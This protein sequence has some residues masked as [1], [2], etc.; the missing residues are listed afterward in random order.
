MQ[1]S[2]K[3]LTEMSHL[4]DLLI[5]NAEELLS[6]VHK[7]D[8]D[9]DKLRELQKIQDD[10]LTEYIL[11]DDMWREYHLEI[12]D[13]P[14]SILQSQVDQKLNQFQQLNIKFIDSI[15]NIC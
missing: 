12:L 11:K 14:S 10:W 2:Q 6:E 7:M 8:I 4:L 5:K 13:Q 3:L 15:K 9:E 1:K